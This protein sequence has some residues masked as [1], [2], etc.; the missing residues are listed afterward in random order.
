MY[1]CVLGG[2][3]WDAHPLHPPLR[4]ASEIIEPLALEL[5]EKLFAMPLTTVYS[6]LET[7][8]ECYCYFEQERGPHQFYPAESPSIFSN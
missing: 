3:G 6:H 5:K 2:G 8:G 1:V 4:F 7:C